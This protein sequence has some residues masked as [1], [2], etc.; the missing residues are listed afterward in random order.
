MQII[1]LETQNK[2]GKAGEIVTVKDGFARN[3]LIPQKK[4]VVANLKNKKNLEARM[5]QIN[6]NNEN[7]ISEASLIKTKL[8]G[9]DISIE[10][11]ANE[12]NKLYGNIN[13][14]QVIEE[15]KSKFSQNLSTDNII[16]GSIKT[17]GDHEI[18][19]RLY[20]NIS[21]KMILTI[22]RKSKQ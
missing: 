6:E 15:I 4:A 2:L 17:L 14:K 18:T 1:L 7:K 16:T 21:A 13:Q 22:N 5:E 8:D 20:D 10:M 19:I 12:E 9:N 11:E 3:Y